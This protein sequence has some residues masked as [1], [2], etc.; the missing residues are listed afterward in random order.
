MQE[1]VSS[2]ATLLVPVPWGHRKCLP[3]WFQSH[4]ILPMGQW[5]WQD[6]KPCH[7]CGTLPFHGLFFMFSSIFVLSA[8][9]KCSMLESEKLNRTSFLP[10]GSASISWA[11]FCLAKCITTHTYTHTYQDKYLCI[12]GDVGRMQEC[13]L[14]S[15]A[16]I[17][18][19]KCVNSLLD[20]G[21]TGKKKKPQDNTSIYMTS[22]ILRGFENKFKNGSSMWSTG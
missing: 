2:K 8:C 21:Q 4:Q 6:S 13:S 22:D 1:T 3:F 11:L 5:E 7:Y 19:R 10:S 9:W 12:K 16:H 20:Y 17:R 18:E 15:I 14:T